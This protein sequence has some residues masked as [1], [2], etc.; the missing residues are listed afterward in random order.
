MGGDFSDVECG[1][2]V[3]RVSFS[4]KARKVFGTGEAPVNF[5]IRSKGDWWTYG[6]RD[7][8]SDAVRVM[9]DKDTGYQIRKR[10]PYG[11]YSINECS[12]M[13][14]TITDNLSLEERE[15]YTYQPHIIFELSKENPE[16]PVYM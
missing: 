3:I 14:K 5:V 2:V 12:Y 4:E 15:L 7:R 11:T 10:L 9:Y 16:I 1:E 8:Y 13:G 6:G